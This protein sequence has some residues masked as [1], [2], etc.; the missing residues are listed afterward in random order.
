M[1]HA[2]LPTA[3]GTVSGSALHAPRDSASS[4]VHAGGAVLR[5]VDS[6]VH[7]GGAVLRAVESPVHAGG[8]VLRAVESANQALLSPIAMDLMPRQ[9]P[10]GNA[11]AAKSTDHNALV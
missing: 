4:P 3:N 7:A 1:P 5:A 11:V 2:A 9:I 6:P 8:A 10:T